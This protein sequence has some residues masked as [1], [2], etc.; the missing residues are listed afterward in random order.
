ME[1]IVTIVL[2]SIAGYLIFSGK[3]MSAKKGQEEKENIA[4]QWEKINKKRYK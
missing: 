1:Y 4:E 3:K 2:L